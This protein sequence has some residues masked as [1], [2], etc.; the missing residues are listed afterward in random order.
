[1]ERV[2]HMGNGRKTPAGKIARTADAADG[3]P[4]SQQ[5]RTL[6]QKQVIGN[7][8]LI[9]HCLK[10]ATAAAEAQ[11][12]V[13]LLGET[14]TGKNLFAEII[15]EKSGSSQRRFISV[16]CRAADENAIETG[17]VTSQKVIQNLVGLLSVVKGGTLYLDEISEL[18]LLSQKR[19]HTLLQEFG[20]RVRV[21]AASQQN[22]EKLTKQGR[23]RSD[24]L[25]LLQCHRIELPALRDRREDILELSNFFINRLCLWNGLVAKTS[26][27]EFNAM[28]LQYPWPGNVRELVNSL[29]QS[30]M[31]SGFGHTIFPK[32]LPSH[33]RIHVTK[34]TLQKQS[35]CS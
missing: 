20:C 23:F 15:H 4:P 2:M 10:L 34:F 19:V 31:A 14:G 35:V 16:D 13:V 11:T 32:H 25:A 6:Q 27:P 30:L 8:P 24:L 1:M 3:Y 33:I 17:L 26:T 9:R 22:L 12:N 21:I 5:W 29:E 18:S 7:S 28:L